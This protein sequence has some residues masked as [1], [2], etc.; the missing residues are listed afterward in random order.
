MSPFTIA[1]SEC[2][3]TSVVALDM[4]RWQRYKS[5]WSLKDAFHGAADQ[6]R[7]AQIFLS[8]ICESCTDDAT[9]AG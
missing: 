9:N 4:R 8:G 5:G 1:C 7:R 6:Y 2:G 3:H